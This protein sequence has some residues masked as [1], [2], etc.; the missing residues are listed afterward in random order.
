MKVSL[1]NIIVPS[2][3]LAVLSVLF[4]FILWMSAFVGERI[5]SIPS[6]S[7]FL[8]Q[9]MQSLFSPNTLVSYLL[10]FSFNLLNAYLLAQLNNKFTL[11][12]TRTFLP[13][14]IFLL[15]T[16]TWNDTH[17]VNGSHV[18]LTLFILSLFYFFEMYRNKKGAEQSFM[19]SLLLSIASLLINPL[20][21]LI[22]VFWIGF[23]MFQ[24]FSMR[25]LLASIF[26]AITPWIFYL[27]AYYIFQPSFN[28]Q[29]LI[30]SN[31]IV[32]INIATFS[33]PKLIYFPLLVIIMIINLV[34]MYSYAHGD[35]IHT[36]IKLNFFVF[37]LISI[38]VITSI[39]NLQIAS[40]LPIIALVY[41]ILVS[42]SF[43]LKQNNFYGYVFIVFFVI[44]ILFT[45]SKYLVF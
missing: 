27:S 19:G 21:F 2:I 15:L 17:I 39:F 31:L 24:S 14:L 41:S 26:G 30:T 18:A 38:L 29:T 9:V 1:K 43:T 44:N 22:P 40:F 42:H 6:Q 4:C 45:I 36:R 5:T 25:T 7:S 37:L 3:P 32:G 33:L 13:I 28:F 16:G 35:V 20:L 12:R 34:G 11:I 23:I 10:S 8:V